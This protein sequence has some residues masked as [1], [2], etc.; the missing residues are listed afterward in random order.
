MENFICY[1]RSAVESD[2]PEIKAISRDEG[3]KSNHR[4]DYDDALRNSITLVACDDII[5]G[6]VVGFA[7]AI[8]DGYVTI[9]LC[10]II[11]KPEYRRYGYGKRLIDHLFMLYPTC[12]MDLLSQADEFY[13]SIGFRIMGNG[14]RRDNG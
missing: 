10:E 14:L 2:Y 4:P 9:Y 6:E 1:I 11:V 3:W 12:R 7:R 13:Q 8:T 5:H